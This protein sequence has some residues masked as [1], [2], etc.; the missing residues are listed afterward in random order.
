MDFYPGGP[1]LIPTSGMEIFFSYASF[2]CYS[3]HVVRLCNLLE[4][5]SNWDTEN[6]KLPYCSAEWDLLGNFGKG[7]YE[8]YFCGITF[9]IEPQ[10]LEEMLYK[11]FFY[12]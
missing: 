7:A 9:E 4:L 8:G 11:D 5:I 10:A 6:Q 1:G 3:F 12:F 2:L